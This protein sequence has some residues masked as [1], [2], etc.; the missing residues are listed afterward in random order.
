MFM[1]FDMMSIPGIGYQTAATI[2]SELGNKF[3]R[4][5]SEKHFASFIG[6]A[7]SLG[8]SAGKNVRQ[9]KKCKNTSHVG[10]ALR[11]G[12]STLN[13]SSCELGAYYR[14]VARQT[15]KKTAIRA[16]ARRMAHMIFR[17]VVYGQA[18]IDCGAEAYEAR[19]RQRTVRTVSRLIK[20]FG[21][22]SS[23]IAMAFV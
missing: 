16:T 22:N 20:S 21:I 8:K 6:L 4:F 9:K 10:I 12:A 2:A 18:Y 13:R 5:P 7:P 19:R 11:M 23:E 15:D 3:D 1:G 17:G 14:N